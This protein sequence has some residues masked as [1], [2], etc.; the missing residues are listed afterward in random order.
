MMNHRMPSIPISKLAPSIVTLMALC[1]GVTSIRYALD[2]KWPIA[3]ALIMIA[4]FLDGID[5]RLARLLN[6]T[7]GFGAQLDSLSDLVSFG[8]APAVVLYLWSLHDIPYRGVGWAVVLFFIACSAIRLARFNSKLDDI[9]EQVKMKDYFTGVPMPAAA[10][11]SLLPLIITFDICKGLAISPWFVA[12]YLIF[13]GILMISKIP[14]A[15]FKSIYV[16]KQYISPLLI[17]ITCFITFLI[18][19][20]WWTLPLLGIIYFSSI[21]ISIYFYKKANKKNNHL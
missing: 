20:P 19:E 8:V 2:L 1:L 21:P 14:V 4:C 10:A 5:G 12:V 17:I 6:T 3:V 9:D 16:K 11:L 7:S 18:I 13:I 15:S